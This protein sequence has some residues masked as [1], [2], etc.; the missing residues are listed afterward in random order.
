MEKK[1]N[2]KL[3]IKQINREFEC[4][5]GK[6]NIHINAIGTSVSIAVETTV[7]VSGLKSFALG[8]IIKEISEDADE[9]KFIKRDEKYPL[10]INFSFDTFHVYKG[11]WEEWVEKHHIPDLIEQFKG[12]IKMSNSYLHIEVE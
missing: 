7:I 2:S 8:S 10:D 1:E 9:M 11:N 12:L 4:E 6:G 3:F 5:V